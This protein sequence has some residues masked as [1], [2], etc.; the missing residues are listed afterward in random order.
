MTKK[1]KDESCPKNL[2]LRIEKHILSK[3]Y[4][5]QNFSELIASLKIAK[6]DIP[7]AQE[8]LRHL[9]QTGRLVHTP[10]GYE[11]LKKDNSQRQGILSLHPRGFG[12]V[13]FDEP[14]NE[15]TEAFIPKAFI[16]NAVNDDLVEISI[17]PSPKGAEGKILKV[18][19]R[20]QSTIV[21]TVDKL[22]DPKQALA[23]SSNL[24]S[25]QAIVS[26]G[27]NDNLEVGH[28]LLLHVD[29]WGDKQVPA[30]CSLKKILGHIDD[31]SCDIEVALHEFNLNPNF[32][33]EVIKEAKSFG[34]RVKESDIKER[35]DLRKQPC[36]TIDPD[37]AKDF[38]DAVYVEKDKN[39]HYHLSV[40]IADVPHYVQ[41]GSALDKE[42]KLRANSTY[43][44]NFVVPMLPHEL[45]SDLC[46]LRPNVNRLTVSVLMQINHEGKLLHYQ[47]VRSV[48]KS[49]KRFTY[50]EALE[51]LKGKKNPHSETLKLMEELC[52]VL[53]RQ[54]QQ[55]GCI[56]FE[57]PEL[58]LKCDENGEPI[59]TE[60]VDYDITHQMIEQFMVKANEVVATH[61]SQKNLPI[62]YRIHDDPSPDSFQAFTETARAFGFKLDSK[63]GQAPTAP[64][65][66]ALF[67][68]AKNHELGSLLITH[69]IKSMRLAY[70]SP[71]NVGH[72]G[73][74][75]DFYTHFTSPIR[76]YVDLTVMRTLFEKP[77]SPEELEKIAADCSDRERKSAR[78]E[79]AVVK[80]KKLRY[81]KKLREKQ[82]PLTLESV[83]TEAK[84]FGI[85]F[86]L[87]ELMSDGFIHVSKLSSDYY[88]WNEKRKYLEGGN[89]GRILKCGEPLQVELEYLDLTQQVAHWK[90]VEQGFASYG[91]VRKSARK[92]LKKGKKGRK[93]RESAQYEKPSRRARSYEKRQSDQKGK[94]QK[95]SK[96]KRR[97]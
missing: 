41:E 60:Q 51:V 35:L 50:K 59:G 26:L 38:D 75:L 46:S 86:E 33:Q 78:A 54:R 45:S 97:K 94:N 4:R 24:P 64:A 88:H 81:L 87:K 8:A 72:Y 43:L 29:S 95:A 3:D 1:Q 92:D 85:T 11:I 6:T 69:F 27:K 80:L 79:G 66:Q 82:N 7:D 68:E 76:R 93:K 63:G 83:I 34:S 70:Y 49:A 71:Q 18:L 84:Q 57:L 91:E 89:S 2:G 32:P 5:P 25:G 74:G 15:E 14:F 31:A 23:L 62:I 58:V 36:V 28:R 12:F 55:R 96:K 40:H 47:I 16:K 39:G 61:L 21:A 65:L 17:T 52:Y 22:C 37:T 53:K 67:E 44:P 90:E 56:E 48:I 20:S 30:R 9:I 10:H 77:K 42:A 13:R 19:E 73:L